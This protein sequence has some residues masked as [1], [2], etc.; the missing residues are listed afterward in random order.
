[1]LQS[2]TRLD[3]VISDI[4][5]SGEINGRQLASTGR[6][7]RPGLKVLFITGYAENALLENGQL[8]AVMSV[9]VKPFSVNIL[10]NSIQQM[11]AR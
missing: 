11:L 9:L 2:N 1:M 7:T 6:L 8:E 10:A 5:L 4:G 3:V